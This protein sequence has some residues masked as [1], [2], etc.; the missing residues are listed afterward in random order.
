MK[1][2]FFD[3]LNRK[4]GISPYNGPPI[5]RYAIEGHVHYRLLDEQGNLKQEGTFR[6]LVTSIGDMWV[7]QTLAQSIVGD[8]RSMYAELGV[9]TTA[10]AKGDTALGTLIN[11][12]SL[13]ISANYPVRVNS[14]GSGEGEWTTWRF[15][16]GAGVSTNGSIG[17]VGMR[18]SANSFIA[19]ALVAPNVNKTAN[20]TLQVDWGWKFLGA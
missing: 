4:L 13:A 7:A 20:D 16:W 2:K 18:T 17:E 1:E 10:P 6:N 15:S 12:S 5:E 14:F 8:T 9:N 19:R 3:E 11:A